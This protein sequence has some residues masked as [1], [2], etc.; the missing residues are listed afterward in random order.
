MLDALKKFF[1]YFMIPASTWSLS[2]LAGLDWMNR[3]PA[4]VNRSVMLMSPMLLILA[5]YAYETGYKGFWK[6]G[7]KRYF[8]IVFILP[9]VVS[10]L[11]MLA[12]LIVGQR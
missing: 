11:C 1:T 2:F 10:A 9:I 5:A 4:D 3:A 7:R 6:A 12:G 8:Y